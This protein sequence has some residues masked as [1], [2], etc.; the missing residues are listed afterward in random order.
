MQ[1][2]GDSTPRILRLRIELRD[3]TPPVWR[4]IDVPADYDFWA[5]HVAIQDA[6]GWEDS[7]LHEFDLGAGEGTEPGL[8]VGLPDPDDPEAGPRAG[9]EFPI[10]PFLHAGAPAID[11]LYDFGDSWRHRV[12]CTE[13]LEMVEPEERWNLPRCIDG[14]R[15]CPPEDC[16]GP[17]GY[18]RVVELAGRPR[19][20]V[21]E[22][23]QELFDWIP[24]GF[25]PG[26][27]DPQRVAFDDPEERRALLLDPG[28]AGGLSAFT[29]GRFD[30]HS[31]AEQTI[32]GVWSETAELGPNSALEVYNEVDKRQPHLLAFVLDETEALSEQARG[33]AHFA[34]VA[35]FRMFWKVGAKSIRKIPRARIE[36]AREILEESEGGL[37]D[38]DADLAL[39]NLAGDL[40]GQPIL[41]QFLA[42]LLSDD[43]PD[44]AAEDLGDDDREALFAV[45][46]V[47]V[48][49]LDAE[50]RR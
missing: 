24:E 27:F 33:L 23:D 39:A 48:E 35:I 26:A 19:S 30:R 46:R 17:P 22:E 29:P 38:D 2:S 12:T 43:G 5:L 47:V 41:N 42:D 37:V 50:L 40:S 10:A 1:P 13:E 8:K 9:W 6:M 49:L 45:L 4:E 31:L 28:Y 34:F 18:E 44:T 7:H 32:E 11:Y 25:D 36:E 20:A 14:A 21:P 15:A 16:G 3:V